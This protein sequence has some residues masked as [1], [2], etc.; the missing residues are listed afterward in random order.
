MLWA[1]ASVFHYDVKQP[2]GVWQVSLWTAAVVCLMR[3]ANPIVLGGLLLTS[4]VVL[5]RDLP[6]A[7]NHTIIVMAVNVT[8]VSAMLASCLK[9]EK[10]G[11]SRRVHWTGLVS[12][13]VSMA[14]G[15]VYFYGAFHKLNTSFFDPSVS[16]AGVLLGQAM[17]LQGIPASA[18]SV[19]IVSAAAWLTL[20]VEASLAVL[21][22]VPRLRI[23][24]VIVGLGFHCFLAFAH[25]IDFA[26]IV[27]ALY[28]LVI[29]TDSY[30]QLP[31]RRHARVSRASFLIYVLV[32][33][34]AWSVSSPARPAPFPW[35]ALQLIA[36]LAA[37]FPL[38]VPPVRVSFRLTDWHLAF[39]PVWWIRACFM[40]LPAL[41]ALNGLTPFLG[42]KTVANYTMFSN[43]RVEGG[44]TNHF[45]PVRA[46]LITPEVDDLVDVW[47]FE[48]AKFPPISKADSFRL[49]KQFRW[50]AEGRPVQVPWAELR[51]AV[52]AFRDKGGNP[53]H[54]RYMRAG[55][56]RSVKDAGNDQE[57][58]ASLGWWTQHSQAFRAVQRQGKQVVCRW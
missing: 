45:L 48:P 42:F 50:L 33:V 11:G 49:R 12:A 30:P 56:T 58:S 53:I 55:I 14:I 8:I 37:V 17:S 36:W 29:P 3:P 51:R 13:P 41:V 6:A 5:A 15:V 35:Y 10:C 40:I 44:S 39:R 28:L 57:L 38:I 24:G 47:A 7:A 26:T 52:L 21:F 16:C 27:F 32:T 1:M 19:D 2:I 22:L 46:L 43:L 20:I 25:F 23:W 4:T 18:L 34:G 31:D 9:P 54:V